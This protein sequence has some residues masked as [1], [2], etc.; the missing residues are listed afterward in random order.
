ME[1]RRERAHLDDP[2][3]DGRIILKQIFK[4]L[5]GAWTG[6]LVQN[7]DKWRALVNVVMNLRNT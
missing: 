6:D 3:L 2:G 1:N 7:G 5:D 4:N